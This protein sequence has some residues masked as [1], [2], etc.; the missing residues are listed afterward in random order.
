MN[1]IAHDLSI[2]STPPENMLTQVGARQGGPAN[3]NY[4]F[5]PYGA[6]SRL[7]R[8]KVMQ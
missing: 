3:D 2:C 7:H 5:I 4:Y 1:V 8:I 6:L